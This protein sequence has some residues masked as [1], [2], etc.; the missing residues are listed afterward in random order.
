MKRMKTNRNAWLFLF[1]GIA[2]CSCNSKGKGLPSAVYAPYISAYTGGIISQSSAIRVELMQDQQTVVLNEALKDNPFHFSPSLKGATFWTDNHTLEFRPAEDALKPGAVYEATF[3]LGDFVKTEK[4]LREFHFSFRVQERDFALHLSPLSVEADAPGTAYISGEL[5][6]SDRL[7]REEAAKLRL[8]ARAEAGNKY[9]VN[10]LPTADS[11]C[12]PF[13]IGGITRKD[14]DFYLKIAADGSPLHIRRQWKQEVLIP[15][16]DSFR[17]LSAERVEQPENG[18]EIVF[19]DPLSSTQDLNGLLEIPQVKDFVTQVRGNKVFAYFEAK[20]AKELKLKIHPGIRNSRELPLTEGRDF[21]FS[22]QNL[23]PQVRLK[24][25]AAILP[26]SKDLRL[27]FQAVNLYAVDLSVIRIY[28]SNILSFLQSNTLSTADELRRAGRLVYQKTLWLD[29]DASK[30]IHQW[31]NYSV[32]L[33]GLIHQE[34]GAIYRLVFSFRQAYSAYPCNGTSH[35]APALAE[36]QAGMKKIEDGQPAAETEADWDTPAVYFDY[37]GT[38][39]MDWR[40][41]NWDERNDPCKPSYYMNT[42]RVAACNVFASDL[43]LLVKQNS[44]HH[45]WV[46]VNNLLDTNPVEGATITVYNFQLQVIGKAKTDGNGWAEIQPSGQPFL[47]VAASKGQKAYVR[48]V[49]GEEQSTSRFDVGG[50]TVENGLK[51]F[52]Y[53]ERGVWRPGDTL[54]VGFILEDRERRI[55]DTHPVT[56]EFYNPQ[57]Q[58][59]SKTIATHGLNGFYRF[60]LPTQPADPTGLWNAYIKVG[61]TAFH[62]SFRIETIRPNRLKINLDLPA[63]LQSGD[64]LN[65][66]LSSAWLTGATASQLKA[67]VDLS[68]S[69]V[70]TQFK[71]YSQYVFNNP[72]TDFTTVK[73]EVFNGRLDAEGKTIFPLKLPATTN[74]PGMLNATFTTRV[75]EPGGEASF[76]TQTIPYSPYSA[77]VGINL[78]IPQGKYIET[79]ENH[80]FDIVTVD[81]KGQP[82]DCSDLSYKI[83]RLDW[84]WWWENSDDPSQ[85]ATYVNNQSITPVA[86]GRLHT[87][88][89]KASFNFRVNYPDWGQY[90]V[91]V[92]DEQGGHATG[93][94]VYVDWPEWRGRSNR[95]NPDGLK[96]LTFSLDKASYGIGE[97]ATAILPAAAG[98]RALVAIENGS[99]VLSR[100]WIKMSDKDATKYSFKV[101]PDMAPNVYLHV[102]LLQP[103]AQTANDLPIRMYGIEPVFVTD[104]NTLLHPQISLPEVL[105]PKTDFKVSVSEKDGKAMT[106]TLAIVDDGL[107]DL[108]GFKTPDPWNEFYAREALGIRTWDMYDQVLGASAGQMS[109]LF[110]IGGDASLKPADQK[111]NR[112]QPVVKFIGPFYLPKGQRQSHTLRLPM[113][114]GS[115]RVMVVAGQDG[116]YGNAE[117]TVQVR[118]PLM[119]LSTLP[120]VL[121]TGE[122]V[123]VPVNVFA[124]EKEVK[125]AQV[126]IEVSGSG[127]QI[128]GQRQQSLTFDKPSDKLC[129]FK[130]RTGA[131][132]GK[133]EIR[134]TADGNGQHTYETVEIEVRNPNPAVSLRQSQWIDPGKS[135]VLPYFLAGAAHPSESSIRLSVYRIPPV[136]LSRRLSFLEAYPYDCT[137]QLTSKALPLLFLPRFESLDKDETAKMKAGIEQGI[138]LLYGRQLPDGGFAYWPGAAVA[139]E[140]ITSYAGLF[141]TLAQENGYAVQPEVLARWLRFQNN[142]AQNWRLMP[143]DSASWLR[144]QS[145]LQQAFRLY[146]LALANAPAYGAMNRM[147]EGGGLCLQ[148][149]W[150]L[151]AAY[152]LA[153]KAEA[154]GE[155]VLQAQTK[156]DPYAAMNRVYGSSERDDAMILETLVLMNRKDEALRQAKRVSDELAKEDAFNTQSTAFALM[157]MGRLADELSGTLDFDWARKGQPAG[158]VKSAK[159]VYETNLP[160]S[161]SSGEVRVTNKGKGMLCAEL[162]VRTKPARDTLPSIAE[163]LRLVVKYTDM[164]GAPLS[165][166]NIRQGTDFRATVTVT[167]ISGTS[168]Y[169]NLA[170]THLVPSGW[171]IYNERLF[172]GA[173]PSAKSAPAYE[174]IRDDRVLD[175]FDLLRGESKTFTLRLQAAYAGS[176]VL[177]AIRCEAMYDPEVQART[178]AGRTLVSR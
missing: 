140:W 92:K 64:K 8:T 94:T 66:P 47:V 58:F 27:P 125:E 51:G 126:K 34:P 176:F 97:T 129:F 55:P 154:A 9:P 145:Q 138:R 150:R 158:E 171:E 11:T 163:G 122:E 43:G 168:D 74:T 110:S 170:L 29:K 4:K 164:N 59:Y 119:L 72:A 87:V 15:A 153:G 149:R 85:L 75:F 48:V 62:K 116:A 10:W 91:Y 127:L 143:S 23:K 84:S 6:F 128:L 101:T 175:Y 165:T 100:E 2:L 17:C 169:Q 108:T 31:E 155:L 80:R 173:A 156:V 135:A 146:T 123:D 95:G 25:N 137:E 7:G 99:K 161:P 35:P 42:D 105:R 57:G 152:A 49:D 12:F 28:E 77:Y 167:N 41:Y 174:D 104:K 13:S 159:A 130:L 96:M 93:G 115:V 151:A 166:D 50:K 3:R 118:T 113:Y 120:R 144:W 20:D 40:Q 32:D 141:L 117:K 124:M 133:A 106:Y 134:F 70:R 177:P 162:V 78:N 83:Y 39:N 44:L 19:S 26:D 103:H 37:N 45:L 38:V 69:T 46:A 160:L 33:S 114:V 142:A 102:I 21:A 22:E 121:S 1:L 139:D 109:A 67:T 73:S 111:A 65:I 89:G 76:Y 132:T 112:F 16:K 131:Q 68:L 14:K 148:A 63:L 61:G 172:G 147:K 52:V 178:R 157:A 24:V 79:D 82:V 71:N 60:D 56:L 88:E 81:S 90:F 54:H 107:L 53:G 98:G 36:Q 18:L 30:D 86:S 136:D 5:R